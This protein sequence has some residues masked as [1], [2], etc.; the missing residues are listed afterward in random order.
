MPAHHK[1]NIKFPVEICMNGVNFTRLHAMIK[2]VV[3]T[4]DTEFACALL[5]CMVGYLWDFAYINKGNYVL[6][7]C[8]YVAN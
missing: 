3:I 1:S 8:T 6:Q 4:I 5:S 2:V 7:L